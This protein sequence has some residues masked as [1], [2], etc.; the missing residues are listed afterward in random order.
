M[1]TIT[2]VLVTGGFDPLHSGHIEY[3]RAAKKLGD[4]LI[5]GL[6]SDEWLQRK[7]G[8]SFMPY[9]ERNA[10]LQAIQYVDRVID[11]DDSDDTACSAINKVMSVFG[12]TDQIIFANGGDRSSLSTPEFEMYQKEP[13]L[14]FVFD[15]GSSYKKNSSSWILR[16]WTAPKTQRGWGYYRVLHED[17]IKTQNHTKVKELT[18]EPGKRLSLQRHERRT[19]YWIVTKGVATLELD[20]QDPKDYSVHESVI[21]P[22]GCWHRLS[23]Q[24]NNNVRIVEIQYGPEC[25]EEDIERAFFEQTDN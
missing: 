20:H 8:K 22:L 5:V 1:T 4:N 7:K 17:G 16:E 14:Q 9:D 23:N 11:F 21:I 18:V 10:I 6:N 15:V 13:N 12:K 3:L 25:I 2:N 19:E 24:T